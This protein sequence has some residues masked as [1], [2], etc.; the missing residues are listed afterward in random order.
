MRHDIW[1]DAKP[2]SAGEC[3][4]GQLEHHAVPA[5]TLVVTFGVGAFFVRLDRVRR[6]HRAGTTAD[7]STVPRIGAISQNGLPSHLLAD[8]RAGQRCGPL[9]ARSQLA[10]PIWNLAKPRSV[11][12]DS[13]SSCL[14]DF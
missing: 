4:A 1:V 14:T 5:W 10:C 6:G 3:L 7:H 13:A 9:P 12:S 11:A 8:A 2:G